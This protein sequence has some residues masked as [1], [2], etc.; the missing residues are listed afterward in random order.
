MIQFVHSGPCAYGSSPPTDLNP[1]AERTCLLLLGDGD[2]REVAVRGS[3]VD[4]FTRPIMLT[5]DLGKHASP[6]PSPA[7]SR[8]CCRAGRTAAAGP[9]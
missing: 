5:R 1:H 4:S 8:P 3:C 6:L 7:A 2:D 9:I